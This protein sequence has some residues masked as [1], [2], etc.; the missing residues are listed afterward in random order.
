MTEEQKTLREK[1]CPPDIYFRCG[2]TNCGAHA[3]WKDGFDEGYSLMGKEADRIK[4]ILTLQASENDDLG[5]E[6]TLVALQREEIRRLKSEIKNMHMGIPSEWAYSILNKELD[7]LKIK[8][9]KYYEALADVIRNSSD[10]LAKK[11]C[12]QAIKEEEQMR[13]E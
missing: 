4:A 10:I 13:Y 6:Y 12:S 1:L 9:D 8:C 2:D 11:R 7:E 5:A 3:A